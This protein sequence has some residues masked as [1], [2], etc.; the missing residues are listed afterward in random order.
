MN[1]K[2][3]QSG[4]VQWLYACYPVTSASELLLQQF[5]ATIKDILSEYPLDHEPEYKIPSHY[6]LTVDYAWSVENLQNYI[7]YIKTRKIAGNCV[8]ELDSLDMFL[9]HTTNNP[10][11]FARPAMWT[12]TLNTAGKIDHVTLFEIMKPNHVFLKRYKLDNIGGRVVDARTDFSESVST[13]IQIDTSKIEIH[14]KIND[15]KRLIATV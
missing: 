1:I 14:G 2:N 12:P 8:V 4:L 11:I 15:Q 6:H 7:S 10:I 9:S 5:S 3:S 13:P